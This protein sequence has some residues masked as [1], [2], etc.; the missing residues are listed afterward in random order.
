LCRLFAFRANRPTRARAG[1]ATAAHSLLRQSCGDRRGECHGDGWGVGRFLDGQPVVTRSAGPAATG[2]LYRT[3]AEGV[4]TTT[5]LAHVRQASAGGVAE[6]NCHPFRHGRWLFAHNGT[7]QG[8]ADAPERLRRLVP[9][10][11]RGLVAGETDSEHAFYFVLGLL[12]QTAADR[13]DAA[14]A[15]RALAEAVARLAELFPGGDAGP[16]RLNLVLTD[17]RVLAASRWGHTLFRCEHRGAAG[18]GGDGPAQPSP[19]YRAV[20]IASEPTSLDETWAEV[21]D[22]TVLTVDEELRCALVP[23]AV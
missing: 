3:L 18:P 6:R 15:G 16:T 1:L 5:L 12:G 2:P 9:A 7:L 14:A 20:F 21:P 4:V 10:H 13:P 17:G 23:L 8:F 11:L 19:D 22:R